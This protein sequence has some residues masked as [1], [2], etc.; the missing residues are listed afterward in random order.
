MEDLKPIRVFLAVATHLSF[1]RA[2]QSLNMTA[3]SVTRIVAKLEAD[4]GQQLLVRT[5]RQVSLTSAGAVVAARMKPIVEEFDRTAREVAS[6]ARPDHGRLRIN[7]PLSMGVRLLPGLVDGFRLAYPGIALD[8]HLTDRMIDVIEEDC[9][10]AIRVSK[11]PT[12]KSTIWRKVCQVPRHAIAAPSLFN[13][14]AIPERPEDID[15][16][17]TLSYS[18]DGTGEVWEFSAG[19]LTRTIRA[20]TQVT[21]NN[22][23]LLYEL[24]KAGCGICVLPDFIVAS[25]VTRGEVIR[26]LPDWDV[27]GLWLTLYYPPYEQFPPLVA[28]F[29]DFFESYVRD[30]DGLIFDQ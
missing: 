9:D 24:A 7:A 2:A 15:P 26:V 1:S 25:G 22:G 3:A 14:I 20:G 21:T 19:S 28:T 11:P 6:A 8:M 12:D 23:D 4:L 13:R 17:T 10:L 27:S 18:S 5:T 29:T 16:A 30:L